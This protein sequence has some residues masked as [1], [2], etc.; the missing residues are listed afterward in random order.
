MDEGQQ[1]CSSAVKQNRKIWLT[2]NSLYL[3]SD[4]LRNTTSDTLKYGLIFL[5]KS[6]SSK[7]TDLRV[8]YKLKQNASDGAKTWQ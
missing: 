8:Y 1:T 2:M 5:S 7:V 4:E 6:Y 3:R